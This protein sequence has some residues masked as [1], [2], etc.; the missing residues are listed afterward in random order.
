MEK[1]NTCLICGLPLDKDVSMRWRNDQIYTNAQQ[2]DIVW[3]NGNN[4]SACI[5]QIK[6]NKQSKY[7]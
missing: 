1:Q 3:V 2:K 7:E 6:L 4:H 5:E